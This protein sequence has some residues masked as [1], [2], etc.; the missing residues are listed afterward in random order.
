ML[1]FCISNIFR[2][3]TCAQ[4]LAG[5]KR[6]ICLISCSRQN[7]TARNFPFINPE[8]GFFGLQNEQESFAISLSHAMRPCLKEYVSTVILCMLLCT[9]HMGNLSYSIKLAMKMFL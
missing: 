9:F 5:F 8:V 4:S 6:P 3:W 1:I 7:E 2:M